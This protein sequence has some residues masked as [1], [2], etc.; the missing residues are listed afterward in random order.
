MVSILEVVRRQYQAKDFVLSVSETGQQTYRPAAAGAQSEPGLI[1]FR[2]DAR[3]FYANANRFVDDVENVIDNAPDPV[4]WL[5]LDAGS[6][7][8]VDYSAGI[9]LGGLLDYLENRQITFAIVHA[10]SGLMDT[11]AAY[12][13]LDRVGSNH[14]DTLGDALAAFHGDTTALSPQPGSPSSE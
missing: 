1:V 6:L 13:L 3:L 11:L 9:A 10:D 5:I 12:D 14:Y 4:R 8:D 7:V 2:Y